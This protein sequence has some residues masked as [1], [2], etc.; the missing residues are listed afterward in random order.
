MKIS[1]KKKQV[2]IATVDTVILFFAVFGALFIRWGYVPSVNSFFDHL[3]YFVPVIIIWL[4]ALYTVGLYSLEI[5]FIGY[6]ILSRI[7]LAALVCTL[8]GFAFFYLNLRARIVPKTI[9]ILHSV[10]SLCLITFWR[11]VY[12]ILVAK[13]TSKVY[14][15]FAG[16]NDAVIDL[17]QNIS[18][19]SYMSYMPVFILA[20]DYPEEYCYNVPVLRDFN[21]FADK[22]KEYKASVVVLADENNL[23]GEGYLQGALFELLQ[24]H[25]YF[26]NISEFYEIYMRKVPIAAINELWFL[27]NINIGTKNIYL[28]IKRLMDI[29]LSVV[30]FLGT[31]PFWPF[32]ILLIK[33]ESPGPAFFK[34]TR[35]GYLGR[36]FV[37]IKFRTMRITGNTYESTLKNDLRITRVGN[38][39][40]KTR[41]D[42]IPQF[43]NIIRNDMSF[44]GPRPERPELVSVLEEEVPFY[45]QRLL[46]KPG[47]SGWDQVSGEYH[48]PSKEDTYK[49]LQYDLYYIKNMSFFLDVSIFFKTLVTVVM[50]A[51]I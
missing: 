51:G 42:E 19:F 18:R 14:V 34:Q 20:E 33:L 16:I 2:F 35:S 44:I 4:A 6:K 13:V 47:L 5:P 8:L 31:L 3:L 46:V 1:R 43:L 7:F 30:F 21:L 27:K 12:N 32:I 40:R 36:P 22:I 17:L 48:S 25:V 11:W 50:R 9:L 26:V 41:I 24:Y 39:L 49:K 38:F 15:A 45:R 10:I 37:L 28:V 23:S 29:V